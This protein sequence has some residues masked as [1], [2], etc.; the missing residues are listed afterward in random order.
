MLWPRLK[1]RYC[2]MFHCIMCCYASPFIFQ[3]SGWRTNFLVYSAICHSKSALSVYCADWTRR[4][5][6]PRDQRLPTLIGGCIG[7]LQTKES[8]LCSVFC[9]SSPLIGVYES[10]DKTKLW[11]S[12]CFFCSVW[13][14][15]SLR[16]LR[17]NLGLIFNWVN[18]EMVLFILIAFNV[19]E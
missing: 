16:S 11:T 18:V 19:N 9:D 13:F 6:E 8:T 3:V 15:E 10:K 12:S 7:R 14:R 2:S 17:K 1:G 4:T 5:K